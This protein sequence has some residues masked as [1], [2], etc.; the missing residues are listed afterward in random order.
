MSGISISQTCANRMTCQSSGTTSNVSKLSKDDDNTP[1]NTTSL[2]FIKRRSG[3]GS[4]RYWMHD[5]TDWQKYCKTLACVPTHK[6][7]ILDGKRQLG[8]AGL[9]RKV[10]LY[11]HTC[12]D[13]HCYDVA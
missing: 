12:G 10:L 9:W 6:T 7:W 4:L 2:T 11:Y 5:T 13:T 8:K 1:G 3:S